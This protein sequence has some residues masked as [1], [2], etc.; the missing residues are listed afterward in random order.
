MSGVVVLPHYESGQWFILIQHDDVEVLRLGL[1]E[2]V[3]MAETVLSM[4]DDLTG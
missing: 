1:E 3:G 2:A 4:A